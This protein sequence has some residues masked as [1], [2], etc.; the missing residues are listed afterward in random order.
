MKQKILTG[1]NFRRI[2]YLV[3]GTALLIYSATDKNWA[4]I[5]VGGYFASMGFFAFGCA[6]GQCTRGECESTVHSSNSPASDSGT[7]EK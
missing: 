6:S 7:S 2:I 3:A 5:V 4:G 1:W